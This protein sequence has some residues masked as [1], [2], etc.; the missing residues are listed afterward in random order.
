MEI[1]REEENSA[2]YLS[3]MYGKKVNS[4]PDNIRNSIGYRGCGI[5]S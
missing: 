1:K 5:H 3:H 2:I 4:P